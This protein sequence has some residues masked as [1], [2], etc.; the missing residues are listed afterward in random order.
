MDK[1]KKYNI[2]LGLMIFFFIIIVAGCLAWGLGIISINNTTNNKI[3]KNELT[4]GQTT[5]IINSSELNQVNAVENTFKTNF[6]VINIDSSKCLNTGDKIVFSPTSNIRNYEEFN[7]NY[8]NGE[9]KIV[10]NKEG[11]FYKNKSL[12]E[13]TIDI[14]KEYIIKGVEASKVADIYVGGY[15]HDISCQLILFLMQDGTVFW[16][17]FLD[18]YQK[19][20]F[21][22]KKTENVSNVI[23][24]SNASSHDGVGGARTVIGI[25]D[26]GKFYDIPTATVLSDKNN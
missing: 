22:A 6:N 11:Y 24:F 26:D 17:D 21:T 23:K 1:D 8:E 13:I 14:D 25:R 3:A 2:I 16:L 18:A 4:D 9:F 5:T 15:G 7:I 19:N 12:S 10:M 20:N